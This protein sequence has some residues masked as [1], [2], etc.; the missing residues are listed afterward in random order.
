M[1][2]DVDCPQAELQGQ[3]GNIQQRCPL[4]GAL[5]DWFARLFQLMPDEFKVVLAGLFE[6]ARGKTAPRSSSTIAAAAPGLEP[7]SDEPV[8]SGE[9]GPVGLDEDGGAGREGGKNQPATCRTK[10]GETNSDTQ[11]VATTE[12]TGGSPTVSA[13]A[14]ATGG[15]DDVDR[16]N[17]D[18]G[19]GAAMPFGE[20]EGASATEV[21]TAPPDWLADPKA[22]VSR[23]LQWAEE[24]SAKRAKFVRAKP[25]KRAFP[26]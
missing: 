25:P 19:N 10:I 15:Q 16:G 12:G 26:L 8:V 24:G 7:T 6:L 17:G 14:T 1:D 5:A 18:Q 4:I 13:T 20:G 3:I 23:V 9:P 22:F 21:G 11:P 2:V